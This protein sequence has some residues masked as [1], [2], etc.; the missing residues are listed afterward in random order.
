M[1][2]KPKIWPHLVDLRHRQLDLDRFCEAAELRLDQ[3]LAL[4]SRGAVGGEV[5]EDRLEERLIGLQQL[6]RCLP[7][8]LRLGWQQAVE[9][10][11]VLVV[12]VAVAQRHLHI[13]QRLLRVSRARQRRDDLA[14]LALVDVAV[15][16]RLLDGILEFEV[17][18][19]DIADIDRLPCL[20]SRQSVP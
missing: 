11:P 1:E 14:E 12:H 16:D 13:F 15:C 6:Q 19:H 5:T 7:V 17:L 8:V 20:S 9:Q 2:R 4:G 18:V 3:G 10:L